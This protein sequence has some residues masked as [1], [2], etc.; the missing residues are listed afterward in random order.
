MARLSSNRYFIKPGSRNATT[1]TNPAEA[2][3]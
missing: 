2:K 3:A 1:G